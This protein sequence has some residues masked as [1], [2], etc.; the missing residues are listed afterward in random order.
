MSDEAWLK[1]RDADLKA[2]LLDAS[3]LETITHDQDQ[4]AWI[5]KSEK[6]RGI[7]R[8]RGYRSFIY[9]LANHARTIDNHR[10]IHPVRRVPLREKPYLV[11]LALLLLH[12]PLNLWEKSR[13][14]FGTWMA[15]MWDVWDTQRGMGKL[16]MIQSKKEED[17]DAIVRRCL[18]VWDLQPAWVKEK[19][20]Y[21]R[22][23]LKFPEIMG[24]IWGVP[25]GGNQMRQHTASGIHSDEM[26]IQE[27][28]E[29]AFVAAKPTIEGGGWYLGIS[30]PSP[31]FF[32]RL[33]HDEIDSS[34]DAA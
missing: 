27:E 18:V 15:C 11:D 4:M 26:A 34:R 12:E 30:T 6:Q 23:H 19:A 29:D 17:S 20:V 14:V 1:L 16:T 3:A 21:T 9:W 28:A 7:D 22:C 32:E 13:Q 8:E 25:Q 31:G 24:E 5:G 2:A 10:P 33:V